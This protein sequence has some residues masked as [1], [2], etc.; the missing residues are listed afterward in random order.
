VGLTFRNG[1]MPQLEIIVPF[2]SGV[3]GV[4]FGDLDWRGIIENRTVSRDDMPAKLTRGAVLV[5][6]IFSALKLVIGMMSSDC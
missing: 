4:F 5:I 3:D 1:V 2:F 6:R